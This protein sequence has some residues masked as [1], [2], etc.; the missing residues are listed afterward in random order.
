MRISGFNSRRQLSTYR[1]QLLPRECVTQ[2][3]HELLPSAHDPSLH[4]TT[5]L[6]MLLV[7]FYDHQVT[8]IEK[9]QPPRRSKTAT[10]IDGTIT[11]MPKSSQLHI[12]APNLTTDS[13]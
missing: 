7:A 10:R 6:H 9:L 4:T 12:P 13:V 5:L 1:A 11:N 3:Q 8:G 2:L